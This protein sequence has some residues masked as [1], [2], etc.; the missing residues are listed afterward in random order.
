MREIVSQRFDDVRG[1]R[2]CA[3]ADQGFSE[4]THRLTRTDRRRRDRLLHELKISRLR[5]L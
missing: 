4:F 5:T 2:M 3:L 1:S